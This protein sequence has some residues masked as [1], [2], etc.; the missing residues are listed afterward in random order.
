MKSNF[1]QQY[2][3]F[4][5]QDRLVVLLHPNRPHRQVAKSTMEICTIAIKEKRYSIQNC[6]YFSKSTDSPKQNK[7]TNLFDNKS[8][9]SHRNTDWSRRKRNASKLK[10]FK[11]VHLRPQLPPTNQINTRS[12]KQSSLWLKKYSFSFFF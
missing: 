8:Q 7:N 9:I 6:N 10:R 11:C 2:A 12:F 5:N 3:I 1:Y 4:H